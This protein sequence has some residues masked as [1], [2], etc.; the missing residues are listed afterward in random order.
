MT[1][2]P[3]EEQVLTPRAAKLRIVLASLLV[4]ADRVVSV[5]ALADE[6]WGG[7]PPR[8]PTATIQVYV[9]H[10]RKTLQAADPRSGRAT[11]VTQ[12]PGYVLR[13]QPGQIDLCDFEELHE[14][15]R[16]ALDRGDFA[17]ASD[18]QRRA[19]ALWRGPM[20]AG[21]PHGALLGGAVAWVGEIRIAA[22][23]QRIRADL[24]L[25]RHHELVTEL[26]A[27][28]AEHPLREELHAHLM[29]ALF[30]AERRSEALRVF[31]EL[32]AALV[33]ELGTEPG[34][35]LQR[36]HQRILTADP[37]LLTAGRATAAPP[38]PPLPRPLTAGLPA[39]DPAF[40]GRAAALAEVEQL[41]RRAP[42]GGCV[43][44][45][46]PVGVGKTALAVE[47]ARRSAEVF[48]DGRIFLDLGPPGRGP[49]SAAEAMVRLLRR[50]EVPGPLPDD[51]EDLSDLVQRVL[52]GRQTLL[53][54][55]NATSEAQVRPL[56]PT[57]AG[58]TALLTGRRLPVG[59]YGMRPVVLAVPGPDEACAL[60]EAAL[61]P[62]RQVAEPAAVAR[63][64]ELCGALPLALRVVAARLVA[65][66]HW[67]AAAL[68]DRLA[69]EGGRLARLVA[70][71]VDVRGALLA[72]YRQAPAA[73]RQAFRLLG[74]LPRGTF[75]L[76]LASAVLGVPAREA[77]R[78][79]EA[80]VEAGLLEVAEATG[81]RPDQYRLHELWRLLAI[82]LLADEPAVTVRAATER[83]CEAYADASTYADALLAPGRRDADRG[84]GDRGARRAPETAHSTPHRTPEHFLASHQ[85]VAAK[86][87]P[88]T[89][90]EVGYGRLD[91]TYGRSSEAYWHAAGAPGLGGGQGGAAY[92]QGGSVFGRGDGPGG[93]GPDGSWW[94][95]GHPGLPAAREQPEFRVA[96]AGARRGRGAT[97]PAAPTGD[98]DAPQ[99]APQ[100][101]QTPQTPRAE[102]GPQAPQ[103]TWPAPQL[104]QETPQH[105]P[106]SQ[107]WCGAPDCGAEPP[108]GEVPR[109]R[110]ATYGTGDPA[111]RPASAADPARSARPAQPEQRPAPPARPIGAGALAARFA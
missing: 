9:S 46:G 56:L 107:C 102:Q 75:G 70:G 62:A 96:G 111:Q 81:A 52:A 21:I 76:W 42:A 34:P 83:M 95:S 31:A 28:V 63:L 2:E 14:R 26:R 73:E 43:A 7:S 17:A 85:G 30:R 23:E 50:A 13:P 54:L 44:I 27:L 51:P 32:R 97:G 58:S 40:T 84:R 109:Q 66:P 71:D 99:Q 103:E 35:P 3:P 15:G 61:A 91:G 22:L 18:L 101:S 48:P 78:L 94:A 100:T 64:S 59:L 53:V 80:L 74:L 106:H 10:L 49:L 68:A 45:A 89:L 105:A 6:L 57:D 5:D 72:A 36:L 19:L 77:E 108:P 88:Y 87:A 37:Q 55:D 4:R 41:L 65:H 98:A 67:S 86:A 79:V 60:L 47:A 29:L 39:A 110:A 16:R 25:G 20:L 33:D 69:D 12:S 90:D 104:P 93:W 82:E 38:G 11:L 1:G 24:Q 8:T 92:E